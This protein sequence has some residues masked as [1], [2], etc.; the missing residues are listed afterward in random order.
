MPLS[1]PPACSFNVWVRGCEFVNGD[2]GLA[3]TGTYTSSFADLVFRTTKSRGDFGA[4]HHGIAL[5][6][7]ADNLV[8]KYVAG[9]DGVPTIPFCSIYIGVRLA[10]MKGYA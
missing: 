7:G 3:I 8:S 9:W 4:G 6:H 1:S 10:L 5:S 2:N